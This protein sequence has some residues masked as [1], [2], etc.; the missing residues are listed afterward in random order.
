MNNL[1]PKKNCPGGVQ[2]NLNWM[3]G[4]KDRGIKLKLRHWQNDQLNRYTNYLICIPMNINEKIRNRRKMVEKLR[5]I[6]TKLPLH[7]LLPN[8]SYNIWYPIKVETKPFDKNDKI[9][10]LSNLNIHEY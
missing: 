1:A 7:Q 4:Y 8:L 9:Y 3:P 6:P 5:G 10:E 2:G